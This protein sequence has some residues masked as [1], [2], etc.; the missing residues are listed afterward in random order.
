MIVQSCPLMSTCML[1][2]ARLH[3]DI[4]RCLYTHNN[5][6]ELESKM[7]LK[8]KTSA[9]A[10]TVSCLAFF[11]AVEGENHSEEASRS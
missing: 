10:M 4:I 5:R 9:V 1:R 7:I 2:H 8:S 6:G 11:P 3:T